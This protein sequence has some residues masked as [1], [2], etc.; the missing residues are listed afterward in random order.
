[1][2]SGFMVSHYDLAVLVSVVL[3]VLGVGVVLVA[4][5]LRRIRNVGTALGRL[6]IQEEEKTRP[7]VRQM[8][9]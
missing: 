1:M 9:R 5:Y 7:L 4:R 8:G 3:A 6:V 2:L